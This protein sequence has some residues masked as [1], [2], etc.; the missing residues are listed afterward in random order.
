MA[1]SR[2][3]YATR[4]QIKRAGNTF[5]PDQDFRVDRVAQSV[6]RAIE[7]DTRTWF[8]P[9]TYGVSFD[10][11]P[12]PVTTY[13][14]QV[15]LPLPAHLLSLNAFTITP[16]NASVI[17]PT[18]SD[19]TLV[20]KSGLSAPPYTRILLRQTLLPGYSGYDPVVEAYAWPYRVAI[21]GVWAH[22]QRTAAAGTLVGGINDSV[23]ALVCSDSSLI[24]VGDPLLIGSEQLLVTDRALVSSTATLGVG[25]IDAQLSTRAVLVS[26]GS[27]V[28]PGEIVTLDAERLYVESVTLNTLQVVRQYDGSPVAAHI[29]GA[30]LYVPRQLS[31]ARAQ[32]QGADGTG[33]TT[34]ASHGDGAA[35]A[36][37]VPPEDVRNA[38]L[39][40]CIAT[41][42][43][44]QAGY[45]RMVGTGEGARPYSGKAVDSEWKCVVGDYIFGRF[46][47]G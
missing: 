5:G 37:Y 18:V 40:R 21:T 30:V 46:Y 35:I 4:E 9:R 32:G 31:V 43:Q 16:I 22:S 7:T 12:E 8:A 38:V 25:G 28:H 41:I 29:E 39:A 26:D 47:A 34:A 11:T 36:V 24:G 23:G 27:K 14:Y 33:G 20:N 15:C 19:Y 2:I 10:W 17:T 1:V 3:C 45:G 6:S 13:P 42:E 44:E